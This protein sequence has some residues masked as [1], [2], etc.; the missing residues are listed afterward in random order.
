MTLLLEDLQH[1]SVEKDKAASS[2]QYLLGT[3]PSAET[4]QLEEE[5]FANDDVFQELEIAEDE[6]I[7]A[8]VH[9]ELSAADLQKFNNL[10][11]NPRIAERIKFAKILKTATTPV[12]N[13]QKTKEGTK[14]RDWKAIISG[15]FRLPGIGLAFATLAVLLLSGIVFVDWLGLRESARQLR[16]DRAELQRQNQTLVSQVETEKQQLNDEKKNTEALNAKLQQALENQERSEPLP[17]M[18]P[19]FLYPGAFRSSGGSHN[20]VLSAKPKM[21]RLLLALEAD[22][23]SHYNAVVRKGVEGPIVYRKS[24]LKPTGNNSARVIDL[25]FQ[26]VLLTPNDY[27]VNLDGVKEPTTPPEFVG[28]YN[29]RVVAK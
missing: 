3:L 22:E 26:S 24:H 18:A 1:L 9:D 7:D 23:Y 8:Y 29:F 21:V 14:K 13:T 6:L 17:L 19:L 16:V 27:T 15:L 4:E 11:Q 25:R 20:L 28:T 10:L 12:P 2:R 5:F